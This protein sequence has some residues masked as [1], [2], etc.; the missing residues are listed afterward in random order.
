[1]EKRKKEEKK[2][3]GEGSGGGMGGEGKGRLFRKG[4]VGRDEEREVRL[5]LLFAYKVMNFI[6]YSECMSVF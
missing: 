5:V 3:G 4:S 2:K 1:M 6:V